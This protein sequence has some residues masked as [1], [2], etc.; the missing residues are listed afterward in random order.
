MAKKNIILK[1]VGVG[2]L[3]IIFCLLPCLL[4]LLLGYVPIHNNNKALVKTFCKIEDYDITYY[5]CEDT[6][7]CG[8]DCISTC[9]R[10]CTDINI[11]VSYIINNTTYYSTVHVGDMNDYSTKYPLDNNVVCY[12]R[13]DNI[14][15]VTFE[16]KD[17]IIHLVFF[18]IFLLFTVIIIGGIIALAY[19]EFIE[20]TSTIVTNNDKEIEMKDI[21]SIQ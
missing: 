18:I 9:Y 5:V 20:K 1:Y 14:S 19:Y 16:H 12:Y 11:H 13:N 7:N 6:C 4:F 21:K 10:N 8:L 17:D 15:M 3:P 2:T